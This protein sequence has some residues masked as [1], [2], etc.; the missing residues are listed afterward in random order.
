MTFDIATLVAYAVRREDGSVDV[1]STVGKF[2][3]EVERMV[4]RRE[5]ESSQ[6]GAAVDR[7]FDGAA[8]GTYLP[9]GYI[10][11][12]VLNLMGVKNETFQ[13]ME[14][15]VLE[16]LSDNASSK[17]EAGMFLHVKKG[18]GYARTRDLPAT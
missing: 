11:H 12:N 3:G 14:K 9:Q 6:I 17:R 2:R 4:A 5:T 18:K 7:V 13:I 10:V 15:R 16:Y 1:E 8:A